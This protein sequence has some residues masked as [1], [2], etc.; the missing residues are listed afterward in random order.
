MRDGTESTAVGDGAGS[1]TTSTDSDRDPDPT[2]P[3]RRRR[4]GSMSR[5]HPAVAL[6]V[7]LLLLAGP[8]VTT[9]TADAS[10]STPPVDGAVPSHSAQHTPTNNSTVVHENPAETGGRGNLTATRGWF[11]DR[12]EAALVDC[13]RRATPAGNGTC[14]ALGAQG[15]SPPRHALPRRRPADRR[16]GR[17]RRSPD[18]EPDGRPPARLHSFSRAVS[19]DARGVPRG[20]PAG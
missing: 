5:K 9:T 17:R 11:V 12:I 10:S 6:T 16:P 8:V 4:G 7:A 1:S 18:T 15:S 2:D 3:F 19:V 14:A 13:A 20:A